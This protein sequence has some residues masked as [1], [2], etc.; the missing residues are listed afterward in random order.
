MQRC[1]TPQ[2]AHAV[3]EA[4]QAK[5]V[6]AMQMADKNVVYP[7]GFYIKLQHLLLGALAAIDKVQPVVYIQGL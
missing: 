2:Q 7:A 1:S 5:I 4:G 6:V 3:N